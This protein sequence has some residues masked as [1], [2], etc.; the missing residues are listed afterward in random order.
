MKLRERRGGSLYTYLTE[1]CKMCEK[2]A[3]MVVFLSGECPNSCYYCPVSPERDGIYANE[4]RIDHPRDL[5]EEADSMDAEGASITGGE[6]L[7][8]LKKSAGIISLLKKFY[9]ED[10]HIHLYTSIPAKNRELELLHSSGLDE[11]RFHPPLLKN[12]EKYLNSLLT[13]EEFGIE[14]GFEIPALRFEPEIVDVVNQTDTFLNVNQLEY[15]PYNYRRMAEEFTFENGAGAVE[16]VEIALQYAKRVK[17]FHYCTSQF[18][19]G[20]QLRNRFKR[21]SS[22]MDP[23]YER[24]DDGTVVCGYIEGDLEKLK[25]FMERHRIKYIVRGGGVEVSP[26]VAMRLAKRLKRKGFNV[27]IIERYPTSDST[28][29]EVIPL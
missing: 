27:S 2:G 21:M 8:H 5:I 6:P 13:A 1:G 18:K 15:T 19:D 9:G 17:R 20:I 16:S 11:I 4:R 10:F 28:V 22:K 3:K 14:C 7:L 12:P 25:K 24:T 26:E 29:V 23:L